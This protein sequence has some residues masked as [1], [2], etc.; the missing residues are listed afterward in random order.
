MRIIPVIDLKGGAVVRAVAGVRRRYRPVRSVLAADSRPLTVATAFRE[1]G[2]DTVYVADLDALGGASPDWDA[3]QQIAARGL[4]IWLDAGVDGI[5]RACQLAAYAE[6][7]PRLST[8][9][10]GLESLPGP[11]TLA[12]CL[13]AIGTRRSMFSLDL[14]NGQPMTV[15]RQWRR[16][17]ARQ[18]VE[19]SIELGVKRA[20]LL[21]L[22]QVGTGRGLAVLDLCRQLHAA[23][24]QVQ[25]VAGGGVRHM[26]DL[27]ELAAAG[28]SAA[29]VA[30][31]LHDGTLR[32][33]QLLG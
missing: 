29:L 7:Q 11:A 16:Q 19:A 32:P 9:I 23:H 25:W 28:C 5:G 20:V 2:F 21:D 17:T 31:A 30:S 18:I 13:K 22:A 8:I 10:L 26:Q 14:R 15:C 33:A 4:D 24:P 27:E 1:A 6:D 12:E 3:L